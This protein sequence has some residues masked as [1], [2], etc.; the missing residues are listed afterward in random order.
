ML[1]QIRRGLGIGLVLDLLLG[2]TLGSDLCLGLEGAK[3]LFFSQTLLPRIC[4]DYLDKNYSD[5]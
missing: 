3:K 5:K 2:L 1:D 4:V